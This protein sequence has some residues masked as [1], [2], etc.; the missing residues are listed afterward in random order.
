MVGL[1]PGRLHFSA[2]HRYSEICSGLVIQALGELEKKWYPELKSR[3]SNEA[4]TTVVRALTHA[5]RQEATDKVPHCPRWWPHL[6]QGSQLGR[7][8]LEHGFLSK[9]DTDKQT[10]ME[11]LLHGLLSGSTVC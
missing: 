6:P 1:K 7:T 11:C 10:N 8:S 5:R 9:S 4:G 3:D 2:T